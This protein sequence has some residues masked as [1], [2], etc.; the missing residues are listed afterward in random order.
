VFFFQDK[1]EEHDE[2]P[3]VAKLMQSA[4]DEYIECFQTPDDECESPVDNNVCRPSARSF[5]VIARNGD[6]DEETQYLV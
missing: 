5:T 2:D 3:K 1:V 4:L 6:S